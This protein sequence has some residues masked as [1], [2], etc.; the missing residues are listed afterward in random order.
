M[1]N[2]TCRE[3]K[4][5]VETDAWAVCAIKVD[6]INAEQV[7]DNCSHFDYKI[8][9]VGDRIRA[10]SD[11]ELVKVIRTCEFCMYHHL[12]CIDCHEGMLAY[13]KKEVKDEQEMS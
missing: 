6:T 11:E 1:E 9:T 5:C 7:S 10:M 13:L 8:K 12:D 3:C 4:W 2:K